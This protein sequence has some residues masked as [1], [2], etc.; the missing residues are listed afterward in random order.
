MHEYF[1]GRMAPIVGLGTQYS[2]EKV[3]NLGVEI[4]LIVLNLILSLF[5][6]SINSS[7]IMSLSLQTFSLNCYSGL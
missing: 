1:F 6:A 5:V 3:P 2:M 4:S 7:H